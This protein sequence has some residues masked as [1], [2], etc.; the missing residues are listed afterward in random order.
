M[1]SRIRP[2]QRQ[3]HPHPQKPKMRPKAM[4]PPRVVE[5]TPHNKN[6]I[7]QEEKVEANARNH[8]SALSERYPRPRRLNKDAPKIVGRSDY[9]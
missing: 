7:M 3:A 6:T 4:R 9:C 8:E 5:A 2:V 1:R